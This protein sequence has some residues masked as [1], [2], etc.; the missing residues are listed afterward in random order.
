M[1]ILTTRRP[2][3]RVGIAALALLAA[4]SEADGAGGAKI[5]VDTLAGG[6]VQ[7]TNPDQGTWEGGK[8]WRAVEAFRVGTMDGGGPEM[9]GFPADI[10]VDPIG[11]VYVLDAAAMEVRVFDDAGRHV[12]TFGRKG[13]G[14][15]EFNQP[16]GMTW[17]PGGELW[18]VDPG[19]ARYS[20]FDTAG[21][22]IRTHLRSNGSIRMPWPGMVDSSGRV[23]DVRDDSRSGSGPT[24]LRFDRAVER[25]EGFA[26][27]E[28]TPLQFK[29]A[30]EG[31]K[32]QSTVP[33]PFAPRSYWALSLDGRIWSGF[34]D[35]YRLELK[36]LNGRTVRIV[37][38]PFEPV[39]V[40]GAEKDSAAKMLDGFV[41][42]GGQ[43]DMGMAPKTK[44]AFTSLQV[45]DRGYLWLEPSLPAGE[46][47]IAFD[48]FDPEGRYV[49][50]VAL[51]KNVTRIFTPVI[52]GDRLYAV[53]LDEMEVPSVVGFRLEGRAAK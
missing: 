8:P 2:L 38:K 45:D 20:V 3:P 24:L 15:G 13:G 41:K 1:S 34:A 7:V 39:P 23:Y 10:E 51:P 37:E 35:R 11:R 17:G 27:G 25:A 42:Q 49:G 44:P 6:V 14:P 40:T 12:R 33:V 5:V 50:R 18:V 22:L 52:R 30:I 9:W 31:G 16:A 48:V 19:N 46:A 32:I 43:V 21:T 53:T 36:E 28:V 4:C 26:L 47:G 29:H